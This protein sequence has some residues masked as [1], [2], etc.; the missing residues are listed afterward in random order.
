MKP[1]ALAAYLNLALQL[2]DGASTVLRSSMALKPSRLL[3]LVVSRWRT[4]RGVYHTQDCW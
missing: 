4:T 3:R 2:T 1:A